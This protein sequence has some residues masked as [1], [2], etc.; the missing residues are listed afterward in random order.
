MTP[1]AILSIGRV[2]FDSI[3]PSPS[4]GWPRGLTTLPKKPS[5][6]GISTIFFVLVTISSSLMLESSPKITTPTE[7]SSNDKIIP[8]ILLGN[9]TSSESIAFFKP[10]TTATPSPTLITV[11]VSNNSILFS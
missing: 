3:F 6:T 10:L 7:S 9:I 4:I 8:K 2:L 1:G 5:P 11:P